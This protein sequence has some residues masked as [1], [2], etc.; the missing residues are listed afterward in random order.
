MEFN[1]VSRIDCQKCRKTRAFGESY[2]PEDFEEFKPSEFED[3]AINNFKN[4]GWTR[5]GV[6]D[7]WLCPNC[8]E[9]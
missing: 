3:S 6:T 9:K 1:A 8:V 4:R 7:E 5:I 2:T